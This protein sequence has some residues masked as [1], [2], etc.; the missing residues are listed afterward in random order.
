[1]DSQDRPDL[2]GVKMAATV[3]VRWPVAA[4]AQTAA[5]LSWA[6]LGRAVP[7]LRLFKVSLPKVPVCVTV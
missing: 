4:G 7:R 3:T 5:V 1:M 2:T 6:E